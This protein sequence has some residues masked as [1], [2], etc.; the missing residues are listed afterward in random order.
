M[1]WMRMLAN[2]ADPHHC[3]WSGALLKHA[4]FLLIV[5]IWKLYME[6]WKIWAVTSLGDCFASLGGYSQYI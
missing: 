3:I 4:S 5:E 2:Y 6:D 1:R